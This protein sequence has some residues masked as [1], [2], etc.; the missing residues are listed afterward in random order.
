MHHFIRGINSTQQLRSGR[1]TVLQPRA[2]AVEHISIINIK[3][4]LHMLKFVLA[5][6]AAR[7]HHWSTCLTATWQA[8]GIEASP[9]PEAHD[10]PSRLRQTKTHS[11]HRFMR[12]DAALQPLPLQVVLVSCRGVV[13]RPAGRLSCQP[14]LGRPTHIHT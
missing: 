13:G 4:Q 8:S 10:V 11:V 5:S 1:A 12:C 3:K 14:V 7:H 2:A 9:P 6:C